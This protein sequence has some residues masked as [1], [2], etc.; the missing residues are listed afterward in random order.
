MRCF[1]KDIN[2]NQFYFVL[3]AKNGEIILTSEMYDSKQGAIN[4]INS[5]KENAPNAIIDDQT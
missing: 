4:G 2:N 3:K 5:I 1:Y